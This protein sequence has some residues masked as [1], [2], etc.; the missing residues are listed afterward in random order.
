MQGVKTAL[1]AGVDGIIEIRDPQTQR[2]MNCVVQVQSKVVSGPFTAETEKPFEYLCD[3]RDLNH[4]LGE[5][6]SVI[7][8]VSRPE[9]DEAYLGVLPDLLAMVDADPDSFCEVRI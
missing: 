3:E 5:N 6:V 9:R 2:A 7:L 4:W 8:I 1:D